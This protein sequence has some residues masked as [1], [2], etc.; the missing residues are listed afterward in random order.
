ML[1][2]WMVPSRSRMAVTNAP[3][4]RCRLAAAPSSPKPSST[5]A[6]ARGALCVKN[7]WRLRNERRLARSIDRT[8]PLVADRWSRAG[9]LALAAGCSRASASE[10]TCWI[11]HLR[12]CWPQSCSSDSDDCNSTQSRLVAK[13]QTTSQLRRPTPK[14]SRKF[15]PIEL[16]TWKRRLLE[17]GWPLR[18]W[19]RTKGCGGKCFSAFLGNAFCAS[20]RNRRSSKGYEWCRQGICWRFARAT[21][22]ARHLSICGT[23]GRRTTELDCLTMVVGCK[24][25]HSNDYWESAS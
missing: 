2:R 22:T 12:S 18:L 6:P 19:C 3:T 15:S 8:C 1:G 5:S 11:C 14:F 24:S 13:D 4:L 16:S 25:R 9:R 23:S 7:N 10:R 21:A 17:E 20:L